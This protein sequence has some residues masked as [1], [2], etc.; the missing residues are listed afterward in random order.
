MILFLFNEAS[1]WCWNKLIMDNEL[2]YVMFFLRKKYSFLWANCYPV[3]WTS[4]DA[5]VSGMD[6]FS[7]SVQDQMNYQP[8]VPAAFNLS[9]FHYNQNQSK[10]KSMDKWESLCCLLSTMNSNWSLCWRTSETSVCELYFSL[11][12]LG[13]MAGKR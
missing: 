13:A 7:S 6:L 9:Y 4:F 3:P 10:E 11:F 2:Q 12:H 5:W 8:H 1:N